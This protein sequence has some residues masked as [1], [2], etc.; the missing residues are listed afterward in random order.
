MDEMGQPVVN[1]FGEYQPDEEKPQMS[2]GMVFEEVFGFNLIRPAESKDMHDAK[3]LTI[4]KMADKKEMVEKFGEA[5]RKADLSAEK[6][7]GVTNDETFNVFNNAKAQYTQVRDQCMLFETYYRPCLAY[8]NG[9]YVFWTKEGAFLEGE[10][11][12]GIFPIITRAYYK[13]KTTPRGRSPIKHMRPYQVEINRAASKI[14]EHQITLGDDKILLQNGTKISAGV[15]LPGVR[16]VNYNGIEPKI[17]AGRDGSQYLNY[18]N[19]QITELYNVM[20]IPEKMEDAQEGQ[21]LDPYVLLY[22]A[23]SKKKTLSAPY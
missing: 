16:S 6:V 9:Y 12:G 4:R 11:P 21:G 2:G 18:M 13:V 20:G 17:L 3:W 7:F 14:A 19:S 10:L 8:P 15:S 22:R 5:C 23:A 1:E